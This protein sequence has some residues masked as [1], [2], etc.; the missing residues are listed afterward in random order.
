VAIAFDAS[1]K[2]TTGFSA[3]AFTS[4]TVAHTASGSDRAL[5]V[6]V[7]NFRGVGSAPAMT[8]TYNGVA[9]TSISQFSRAANNNTRVALFGIVAPATGGANI[10]VTCTACD[11]IDLAA[12]S[13]TGVD[14]TTAWEGVQTHDTE[15]DPP[16]LTTTVTSEAGDLVLGFIDWF[17]GTRTN[18]AGQT[19]RVF[20]D[21]AGGTQNLAAGEEAG[22]ASV[23]FSYNITGTNAARMISIN[24]NAAAGGAVT[25]TMASTLQKA[26]ASF[27][28]TMQPSGVMASTLQKATASLTGQ[29]PYS[30]AIASTLQKATASLLGVMQPSGALASTLQKA[31]ASFTGEHAAGGEATG[32]M[33]STLQAALMSAVG[34]QE[35]TGTIAAELQEALMSA[36]G[37]QAQSGQLAATLQLLTMA[38]SG[39]MQPSGVLSSVLQDLIFNGSGEV[40]IS[41]IMAVVMQELEFAGVGIAPVAIPDISGGGFSYPRGAYPRPAYMRPRP[42]PQR[43]VWM[44][45]ERL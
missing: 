35:Q 18:G 33:A 11:E 27:T 7:H 41:G 43:P 36:T 29:Q 34:T 8:A 12:L 26:T 16:N 22:A 10:V 5:Y 44:R 45:R 20:Q 30:G 37:T 9:M 15:A 42:R 25:G 23:T 38:A 4:L 3:G 14:Q 19:E 31:T 2:G 21:G 1:S 6:R 28:G 17:D 39:V 13:Y 40:P 32:T 24:V